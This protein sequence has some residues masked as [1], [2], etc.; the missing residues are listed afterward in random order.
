MHLGV[1]ELATAISAIA[2]ICC[3]SC[4]K[5]PLGEDPKVQ[6]EHV[7]EAKNDH[8]NPAAEN[9]SEATEKSNLP[10]TKASPTPVE[11]FPASSPTP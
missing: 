8:Q 2:L 9:N 11:F 10:S 3:C 5:H 1:R 4:E 6:K 7:D